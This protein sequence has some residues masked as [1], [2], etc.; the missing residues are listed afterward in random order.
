MKLGVDKLLFGY[1]IIR[2]DRKD[3]AR[4]ITSLL[5]KG[6]YASVDDRCEIAISAAR[7]RDYENALHGICVTISQLCGV[8]GV[9]LKMKRRYGVIAAAVFLLI[10][11]VFASS[12]V[13]DVRVS[14]NEELGEDRI[15]DQLSDAGLAVGTLWFSLSQDKVENA[16]LSIS[17][18]IAWVNVNRR[19]SVAYVVIR[20]KHTPPT[21][22]ENAGYSNVVAKEDSVITDITVFSG[23]PKVKIGDAVK[24]GDILISGIIPEELGGGFVRASG[25]VSG[26][27]IR[28][29][30][31]SLPRSVT[32]NVGSRPTWER[33]DLYIFNFSINIFKKYR[34]SYDEC[35]IIEKDMEIRLPGGCKLPVK[36]RNTYV[37]QIQTEEVVYTDSELIS[38]AGGKLGALRQNLLS[39]CEILK[40]RTYGE[41]VE[42]GYCITSRAVVII[43]IGEEVFFY[44]NG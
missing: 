18:N 2:F 22:V 24:A 5:K 13:W 40:I 33:S 42:D 43:P 35:A 4:V 15:L 44:K 27:A 21:D 10:Y 16:L 41:F 34:K 32:V 26:R 11:F 36:I 1:K 39:E 20:E 6:L 29:V 23:Y 17:E 14:G 8:P 25:E 7:S 31:T 12:F 3:R 37:S 19:G 30:S 38:L 9:L 28:T